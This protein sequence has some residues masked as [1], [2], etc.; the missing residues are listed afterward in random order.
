MSRNRNCHQE[1][2]L[3]ECDSSEE[4]DDDI[5]L[6]KTNPLKHKTELCKTFSEMGYCNY[7]ENCRFAHGKHELVRLP[8]NKEMKKR[9]CKGYWGKSVCTYGVRCQ[10]GHQA[11]ENIGEKKLLLAM[12]KA[13]FCSCDGKGRPKLL[14]LI[15]N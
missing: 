5:V 13:L 8:V 4:R 2:A 10:F 11:T 12:S 6:P 3:T 14:D 9:K 15:S 7:G 1:Q